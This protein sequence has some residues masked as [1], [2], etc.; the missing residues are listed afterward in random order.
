MGWDKIFKIFIIM[1]DPNFSQILQGKIDYYGNTKFAYEVACEEY[2]RQLIKYN[3][4]V[5]INL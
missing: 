2:V 1:Q 4:F 5:L 3:N